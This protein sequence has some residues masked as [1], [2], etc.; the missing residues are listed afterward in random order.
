LEKIIEDPDFLHSVVTCDE[1]R[2]FQRYRNQTANNAMEI[3]SLSKTKESKN[4]KLKN[5]EN[6]CHFLHH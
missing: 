2:L 1:T 5:Q 4:V 3:N 6:G